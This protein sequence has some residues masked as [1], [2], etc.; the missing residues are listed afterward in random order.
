MNRSERAANSETLYTIWGS[1]KDDIWAL[2][3]VGTALRYDG[4]R[5]NTVCTPDRRCAIAPS[6]VA[7]EL[8]TTC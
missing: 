7:L 1:G 3:E 4:T 8:G 5:W 6:Q 2:G